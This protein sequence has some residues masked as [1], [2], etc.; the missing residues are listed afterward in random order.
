MKLCT[1]KRERV[2]FGRA[3]KSGQQIE[4][5]M[6]RQQP[7]SPR[8]SAAGLTRIY[9]NGKAQYQFATD[10]SSSSASPPCA[11]ERRKLGKTTMRRGSTPNRMSTSSP[12]LHANY[13]PIRTMAPAECRPWRTSRSS[14]SCPQS[15]TSTTAAHERHTGRCSL[16][17]VLD[18]G[19]YRPPPYFHALGC[20]RAP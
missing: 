17:L 16:L 6:A 19:E 1:V 14:L 12:Q 18:A 4:S 10:P 7:C 13:S 15:T 3:S 2:D 8:L 11:K 20:L 9:P 5:A